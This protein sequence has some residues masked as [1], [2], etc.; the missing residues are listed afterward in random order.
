[1]QRGATDPVGDIDGNGGTKDGV[2]TPSDGE[3]NEKDDNDGDGTG[4]ETENAVTAG[5]VEELLQSIGE[6]GKEATTGKGM[7]NSNPPSCLVY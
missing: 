2:N 4:D 1:M 5:N 6:F 7:F 3:E